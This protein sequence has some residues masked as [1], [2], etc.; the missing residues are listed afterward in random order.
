MATEN[1]MGWLLGDTVIDPVITCE[2]CMVVVND[3]N[4]CVPSLKGLG[5][6]PGMVGSEML[7]HGRLS[8]MT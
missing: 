5:A 3:F 8:L 1:I 7:H 2:P 6:P 4:E